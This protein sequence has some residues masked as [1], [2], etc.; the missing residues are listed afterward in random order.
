VK[1]ILAVAGGALV[2]RAAI[3]RMREESLEGHVAVITG[4]SRG[5][6]LELARELARCG[7]KL[8]ICSRHDAEIRVA[9]EEL[10]KTAEVVPVVCDVAKQDDVAR[11]VATANEYFGRIDILVNNAGVMEVGPSESMTIADYENLMNILYWGTVYATLAVLPQMRARR[12]GRIVNITSIGGKISVPHLL[13]YSGAKFAAVGFSEGLHEEVAKDGINVTTVVPWLMRTGGYRHA[14]VKGDVDRE[15]AWFAAA[16]TLPLVTVSAKRAGRKIVRG[17]RRR[18][19]EV[20]VGAPAKLGVR[21]AGVMP[22][23]MMMLM[24]IFERFLPSQSTE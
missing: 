13:P 20:I 12:S 23:K 14:R 6:G 19:R 1:T 8:V 15:F 21:A 3:R 10:A 11:L 24:S 2:A 22:S 4:A 17:I 9:A 18:A 16:S 7:C 5:L